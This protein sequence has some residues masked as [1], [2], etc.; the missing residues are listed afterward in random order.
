MPKL[1]VE[2]THILISEY[3]CKH[4]GKLP[5]A[6]YDE[7][8][9]MGLA[10]QVLFRGFEN[11]RDGRGGGSLIVSNGYRCVDYE[12][13]LYDAWV[14]AGRP[15]EVHGFLSAHVF[16][17]ALDIVAESW[18]DQDRIVS[19]AR[20]LRPSPRIG[21]RQYRTVGS[22][23]VHLDYCSLIEP[24]PAAKFSAGVEW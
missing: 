19:L 18:A 20:R 7:D 1:Y 6:F 15:G 22:R 8:G 3:A 16:G 12:Q 14:L 10:Y 11:I 23:I 17:L 24:R 9:E 2:N 13:G 4:C 5:P 21:W